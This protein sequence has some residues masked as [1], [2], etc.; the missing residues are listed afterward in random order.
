[1]KHSNENQ[2]TYT[3]APVLNS[4]NPC[5]TG[6]FQDSTVSFLQYFGDVCLIWPHFCVCRQFHVGQTAGQNPL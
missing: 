3:I 5:I 2:S 1:V 6:F 4:L